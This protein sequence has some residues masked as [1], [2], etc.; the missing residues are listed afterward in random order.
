MT[1]DEWDDLL[2]DQLESWADDA[3]TVENVSY[4]YNNH[5]AVI[6]SV[7]GFSELNTAINDMV[8]EI[9]KG[10]STPQTALDKYQS[11]I[12]A[13]IKDLENHDYDADM[14]EIVKAAE[15]AEA[16]EGEEKSE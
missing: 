3:Q 10:E 2:E 12:D 5:I 6:N 1:Q 15:E 11:L 7:N 9:A 14:Q 4:I 13:A 16:A 8:S